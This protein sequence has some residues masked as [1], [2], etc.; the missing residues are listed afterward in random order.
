MRGTFRTSD[1]GS[2][3]T[4][5]FHSCC[6]GNRIGEPTRPPVLH[7]APPRM[8]LLRINRE[9]RVLREARQKTPDGAG[10]PPE[11]SYR[12]PTS[13]RKKSTLAGRGG[14]SCSNRA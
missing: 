4:S 1:S 11:K 2:G 14:R 6:R 13:H 9:K 5:P 3:K 12:V 7:P 8:V 10:A